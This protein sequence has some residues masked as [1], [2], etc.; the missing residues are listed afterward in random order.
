MNN[1]EKDQYITRG[2]GNYQICVLKDN[3][4]YFFIIPLN[5]MQEDKI[6]YTNKNKFLVLRHAFIEDKEFLNFALNSNQE[7][8]VDINSNHEIYKYKDYQNIYRAKSKFKG[9]IK[10]IS[11][12]NSLDSASGYKIVIELIESDLFYNIKNIIG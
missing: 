9:K 10:Y 4:K 3:E 6:I 5:F 12:E 2:V 11:I 7:I 8:Y 1:K